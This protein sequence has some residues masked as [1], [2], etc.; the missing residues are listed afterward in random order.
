MPTY[1]A[2]AENKKKEKAVRALRY[3]INGAQHHLVA[4]KGGILISHRRTQIICV[5]SIHTAT[6]SYKHNLSAIRQSRFQCSKYS[7]SYNKTA[8]T[9]VNVSSPQHRTQTSG[10]P[11]CGDT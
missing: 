2:Q 9:P 3:L 11:S 7:K 10:S 5:L 4:K 1:Y 6:T 8:A